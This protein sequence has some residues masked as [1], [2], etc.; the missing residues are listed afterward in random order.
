MKII[1]FEIDKC[2]YCGGDDFRYG[3][4]DGGA[5][6][7]GAPGFLEDQEMI[8]HL[9]CGDCGSILHSWVV[10]PRKY[11]KEFPDLVV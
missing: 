6:M 9:I 5:R 7:C 11:P 2:P 4:S 10:N 1:K 8:H 3:H